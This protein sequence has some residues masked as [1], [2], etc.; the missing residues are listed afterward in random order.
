MLRMYSLV[1][2]T[3]MF[4]FAF[5]ADARRQDAHHNMQCQVY[6]VYLCH[7]NICSAGNHSL[8]VYC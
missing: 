5:D 6:A 8:L 3:C 2:A 7:A 1:F 4:A